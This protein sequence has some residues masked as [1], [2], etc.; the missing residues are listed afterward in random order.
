VIGREVPLEVIIA[1][2]P[3]VAV[4]VGSFTAYPNG[5]G[6]NL[7]L[8]GK[9]GHELQTDDVRPWRRRGDAKDSV[10]DLFH[11]GIEFADGSTVT[12]LQ[13]MAIGVPDQPRPPI[14]LGGGGGGSE[15]RMDFSYWVWPLPPSGGMT[16]FT[17]WVAESL[18]LTRYEMDSEPIRIA[19]KSAVPVGHL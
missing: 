4:A 17:K 10:R 9:P 1:R 15:N 7:S 16:L 5:F 14:L 11:F 8:R 19:G 3:T 13:T 2:S 18:P 12:N 6:F